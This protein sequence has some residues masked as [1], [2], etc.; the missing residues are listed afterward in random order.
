MKEDLEHTV[1]VAGTPAA[2]HNVAAEEVSPEITVTI[3]DGKAILIGTVRSC[4]ER[5]AA[6]PAAWA[7]PDVREI[8]DRLVVLPIDAP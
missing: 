3:R 6:D 7:F 1:E 5:R 8:N 2:A 4:E